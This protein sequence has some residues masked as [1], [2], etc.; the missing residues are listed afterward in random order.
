LITG[1]RY[2]LLDLDWLSRLEGG[3]FDPKNYAYIRSIDQ[4]FIHHSKNKLIALSSDFRD[5]PNG[6]VILSQN[7]LE[8]GASAEE[9]K[10]LE[11]LMK[12][13][14]MDYEVVDFSLNY[15]D[16]PS[17]TGRYIVRGDGI[18]LSKTNTPVITRD[19]GFYFRGW[20]YDESGVVF[21]EGASYLISFPEFQGYYPVPT[22]VL[23]LRLP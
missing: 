5:N 3:K 11:Q 20:Y 19:M 15:A 22:P 23:K 16:V 18:Y 8:G 2:E 9:G 21:K 14:G 10:V 17:P 12:D 1:Q 13:L 4:V 7:S 6:R